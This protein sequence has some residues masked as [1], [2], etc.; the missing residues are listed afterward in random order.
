M[1]QEHVRFIA[2]EQVVGVVDGKLLQRDVKGRRSLGEG[3]QGTYSSK[4]GDKDF[5]QISSLGIFSKLT[6]QDSC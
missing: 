5:D 1:Q 6:W 2:K 3:M 4:V